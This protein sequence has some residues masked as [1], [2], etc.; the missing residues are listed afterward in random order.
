MSDDN[1]KDVL[2]QA[3]SDS[4]PDPSVMAN[5]AAA[6]GLVIRRNRRFAQIGG[7]AAALV[8]VAGGA[9]AVASTGGKGGGGSGEVSPLATGVATSPT[10]GGA[11]G[12]PSTGG[13][14]TPYVPPTPNTPIGSNNGKWG[15]PLRPEEIAT[16]TPYADLLASLIPDGLTKT[17]AGINPSNSAD[18]RV[19]V[20]DGKGGALLK[21][22]VDWST[23]PF[24]DMT[25]CTNDGFSTVLECHH[26][27]V[28][29]AEVRQMLIDG[30]ADVDQHGVKYWDVDV[31][32]KDG[33]YLLLGEMNTDQ[34]GNPPTRAVAPLSLDQL[35][36]IA[37]DPRW[38][39]LIQQHPWNT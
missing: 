27:K 31:R 37:E 2:S 15:P 39:T 32:F 1:L 4:A 12:A 11:D 24:T 18:G 35:A 19:L 38:D 28:G 10:Q 14:G 21:V 34:D 16:H 23:K 36:K 25:D 6:R 8:L 29:D 20:D 22:S 5:S 13:S 26:F 7:S 9:V 3:L 17:T 33:M 30:A